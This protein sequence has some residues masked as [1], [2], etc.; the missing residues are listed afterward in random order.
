VGDKVAVNRTSKL[1]DAVSDRTYTWNQ[2]PQ[3]FRTEKQLLKKHRRLCK[4]ATPVGKITL[5]FDKPRSRPKGVEA[6]PPE[7]CQRLRRKLE[8]LGPEPSDQADIYRLDRAGQLATVSLYDVKD[9]EKITAFTEPESTRLLEYMVWDHCHEDHFITEAKVDGQRQRATWKTDIS[10]PDLASHLAGDRYFG[11]KKG[12]ATMQVT[13]DCDR[14]SGEVPGDYHVAKTFQIGNILTRRFPEYRWAPEVNP[15]NGSVKFFG[16]LSEAT[17]IAWAEQV[18]ERVRQ[19]LQKE[20]P[21][22]DFSR[23]EIY[24]CN[25]PQVFAPLRAD[26]VTVIGTGV[27]GKV[28][29]YRME[30]YNGKRRRRYYNA[31]SCADFLNWIYFS[32]TQYD[33]QVFEAALREAAARCPDKPAA[34]VKQTPSKPR[35][36]KQVVSGGMGDIGKLQGRCA[37]TLVKFWSEMDVPEQDTIG[38]YLIATLRIL[39][40]EGLTREE[41]VAWVE[42]RLQALEYTEFS[43]RLTDNLGELQRVMD[44]AVNAVWRNNGYQKDPVQSEAKLKAAV[45][46]WSRRG[47]YLHDPDTWHQ[48][49]QAVVP[50]LKLVWTA[51][52]LALV[53]EL[54]ALAHATQEQTKDF[55]EKLLV[56]VETHNELAESVVGNLLEEA[57]IKGQSRQKQHDVR[58][59]L[60]DK[61]LLVK[62]KNYYHD[63]A[64][65]YRHGNFYICGAGVRFEGVGS[66]NTHPVSICY[67]S[68][69]EDDVTVSSADWLD[70]LIERRRLDCDSRYRERLRQLRP[71][72]SR[73]A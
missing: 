21:Q 66:H 54:A 53:P 18:G 30:S 46:A 69:Q 51:D 59:F 72:F 60:V 23:L 45:D 16:W 71:L 40:Y 20:L 24:P 38:K 17:P 5:I 62:Q 47:F 41:A 26:K 8:I 56:F 37:S 65:G 63:P 36:K 68:L 3:H 4:T 29:K 19:T 10:T 48:H 58:K 9:T 22:Y 33:P 27:L 35:P 32:D 39:R 15:R 2:V 52:L 25:S 64:T 50:Q 28:K 61:G 7:V 42:D 11:V 6:V 67:L 13:V 49:R 73:A 14:H 31:Y 34:E 12:R 55:I 57:S 44:Y 70:L 1:H 43:D